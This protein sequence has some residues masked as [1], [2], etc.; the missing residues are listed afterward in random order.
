MSMWRF[1]RL[2]RAR[3]HGPICRR[4]RA[5]LA[6]GVALLALLAMGASAA[7]AAC[8][9]PQGTHYQG[10]YENETAGG[11]IVGSGTFE[12]ISKEFA[13][14]QAGEFTFNAIAEFKGTYFGHGLKS[15]GT[16]AGGKLK[17]VNGIGIEEI[18]L[19]E[20]N[21]EIEGFGPYKDTDKATGTYTDTEIEGTSVDPAGEKSRYKGAFDPLKGSAGIEPGSVEV[22]SPAGTVAS[23]F[24][25]APAS[26]SQLPPG[27]VAPAGA[28]SFSVSGVPVNGSIHVTLVLPPGSTPTAV[29]KPV[30]GGVYQEYPAS[31]TLLLGNLIVLELTDN[32]SPWDENPAPGVI[33][34]PA[35]PVQ[36][37][38]A[39]TTPGISMLSPKKG[40]AGGGTTVTIT[41]HDFTGATTVRFGANEATSFSVE[42]STTIS[43]VA[44]KG[45]VGKVPVFV[46]TPAGLS[47]ETNKGRFTY[48]KPKKQK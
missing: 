33:G 6:V 16:I 38:G 13:E 41:G 1:S 11:A 28:L 2:P 10:T 36:P 48:K 8:P 12:T 22:I 44:P 9:I 32:E 46:A 18:P 20:L 31:K 25:V 42:S 15:T 5:S 24:T 4:A 29:Y 45:T 47:A 7:G 23:A 30:G 19:E 35:I 39:G 43:A 34:D 3:T 21:G 27:T 37:Q 14:P 40:P 17:C 26:G